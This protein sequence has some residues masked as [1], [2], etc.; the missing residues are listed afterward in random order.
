ML[1]LV[2]LCGLLKQEK[3]CES[4]TRLYSRMTRLAHAALMEVVTALALKA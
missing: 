3:C 1:E 4:E 2:L